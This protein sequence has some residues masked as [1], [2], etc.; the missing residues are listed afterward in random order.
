M[1][2][3]AVVVAYNRCELLKG[4]LDALAAQTRAPDAVLVVDNASS[5][6]SGQTAAAHPV[7]TEVL[8]LTRNTGG[9]GGF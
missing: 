9:A 5:D 3:V 4:T 1:R 8:I 6:R 7:V 2:I